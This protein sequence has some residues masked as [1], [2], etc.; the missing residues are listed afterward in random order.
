LLVY[1]L[2]SG[3][4]ESTLKSI[5]ATEDLPT[6]WDIMSKYLKNTI[7]KATFIDDLPNLTMPVVFAL[8]IRDPIVRPDQTPALKRLKPDMEIR[9]IVGL[10]ADHMLLWNIPERVAAEIMRDEIREL[11]VA[12]RGGSGAPLVLLHGIESASS[13]WQPAADA[14][15]RSNDVAVIDLLGF[16][17]SPAPLSSH[18]TLADQVAGVLG[19]CEKLWGPKR[20]IRFAGEGL[21]A[22]VALGCAAEAPER[23]AGVIAFSPTLLEPGKT[24]EDLGASDERAARI[25]ATREKIARFS[26]DEQASVMAAEKTEERIVPT[27]RSFDYAILGT[28]AD[29]LLAKVPAPVLFVAPTKDGLT[30]TDYLKRVVASR[31]GFAI[32]TPVGARELPLTSP[33]VAV[34]AIQPDD[35]D[36]ATLAEHAGPARGR[37]STAFVDVV[38]GVENTMLRNGIFSIV[39]AL[40]IQVVHPLPDRALTLMF[41][42]WVAFSAVSTV[43]GA[44]GL[45]RSGKG[46][47]IPYFLIG[48]VGVGFAVFVGIQQDKAMRL[49]SLVIAVYALYHGFADLY[50]AWKIRDTAKPKWLLYLSGIVGL[51]AALAIFFAPGGG[52]NIVRI[53]LEIYLLATGGALLAY[54]IS[55]KMAARR[56]VKA[57]LGR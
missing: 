37:K 47:W 17:D 38:G 46:A 34:R 28:D 39:L 22:L 18:Y 6:H 19:T 53:T 54:A 31:E 20:A 23:S 13:T 8:G 14:L 44:V 55:V 32:Q 45:R 5:F 51:A 50:V 15:S 48:V 7:N 27:I 35:S 43:L 21:G 41:A 30:P 25:I 9:R 49:L 16:G 52:R 10:T 42:T 24:L 56:R 2:A 40:A 26:V 1:R 3:G 33:A 36:A 4:L 57:L 11:N 12:W 29:A